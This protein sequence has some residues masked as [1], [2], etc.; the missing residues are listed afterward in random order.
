MFGMAAPS[1]MEVAA[2]SERPMTA[3]MLMMSLRIT[4]GLMTGYPKNQGSPDGLLY[5]DRS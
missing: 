4:I 1:M 2:S 5:R 3:M